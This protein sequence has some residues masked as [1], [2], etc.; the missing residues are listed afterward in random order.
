MKSTKKC[1]FDISCF[2][3][4]IANKYFII[5]FGA[6][7]Q[8]KIIRHSYFYKGKNPEKKVEDS[9]NNWNL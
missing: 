1:P 9:F 3:F 5:F 6:K 8:V 2:I 7:K 4:L